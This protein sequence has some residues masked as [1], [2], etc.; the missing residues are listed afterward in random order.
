MNKV[1]AALAASVVIVTM[2]AAGAY[3]QQEVTLPPPPPPMPAPTTDG[4]IRPIPVPDNPGITG[5][6]RSGDISVQGTIRE[7]GGNVTITMPN[8]LTK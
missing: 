4:W 5:G 7:H 2:S 8:P 1:L 6:V 3:A